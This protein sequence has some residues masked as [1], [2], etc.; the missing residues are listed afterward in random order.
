MSE[1]EDLS[2]LLSG[3]NELERPGYDGKAYEWFVGP[4]RV[5]VRFTETAMEVGPEGVST[6]TER[7]LNTLGRSEAMEFL[8]WHLPPDWVEFSTDNIPW[9]E[10]GEIDE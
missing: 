1:N 2:Y 6:R 9:I 8:S 7:A 10:G 5:E 3:P 4:H